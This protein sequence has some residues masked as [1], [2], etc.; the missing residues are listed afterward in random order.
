MMTLGWCEACGHRK[1]T[2]EVK[3]LSNKVIRLCI[4][5]VIDSFHPFIT[6][7]EP[8]EVHDTKTVPFY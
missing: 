5:C 1:M 6:E 8:K 7:K 3:L 4:S 2:G